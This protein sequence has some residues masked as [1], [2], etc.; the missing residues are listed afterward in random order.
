[1]PRVGLPSYVL[2]AHL[3]YQESLDAVREM[4]QR[5]LHAGW[6]TFVLADG[7]GR[8]MN[9]EGA[10]DGIEIAEANG[11][12]IRVGFGTRRMSRTSAEQ[13]I[14]RHPRCAAMDRILDEAPGAADLATLQQAFADPTGGI[15]VGPNTIDMMVFD[16]TH[17]VA[18]LSRG[19]SYGTLWRQYQAT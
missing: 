18:H 10:P 16:T 8:L 19:S 6:F 13:D 4:A 17:R 2:L 15:C 3:L 5:N 12:L 11:R 14:P 1:M 7:Q 9:V